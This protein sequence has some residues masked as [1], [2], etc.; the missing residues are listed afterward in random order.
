MRRRRVY[1][2]PRRHGLVLQ[3]LPTVPRAGARPGLHGADEL[4]LV[5][6]HEQRQPGAA[7]VQGADVARGVR[8]LRGGDGRELRAGAAGV[9]HRQHLREAG[10]LRR[11]A[12]V[13]GGLQVRHQLVRQSVPRERGPVLQE[14]PVLQ[15]Q[16][17]Q[18]GLQ[19]GLKYVCELLL[20][21]ASERAHRPVRGQAGRRVII[22]SKHSLTH[23]LTHCVVDLFLLF[24]FSAHIID[25]KRHDDDLLLALWLVGGAILARQAPTWQ[26]PTTKS[27]LSG[28]S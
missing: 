19:D 28:E 11:H 10:L 23:S 3:R 25:P 26:T 20:Q 1:E 21:R 12:Q 14:L 2:R 27:K 24:S 22:I 9:P 18:R 6:V 8:K 15:Q 7:H 4:L 16:V 17:P 13:H 5:V